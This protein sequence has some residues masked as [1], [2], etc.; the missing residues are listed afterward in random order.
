METLSSMI[1]GIVF[2]FAH[3][4]RIKERK[5]EERKGRKEDKALC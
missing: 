2:D 4:C 1:A 5:K 3:H